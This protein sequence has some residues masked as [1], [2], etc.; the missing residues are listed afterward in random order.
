[1]EKGWAKLHG[2]YAR[3]E[4]TLACFAC[5]HLTGVPAETILHS[6]VKDKEKF[7]D[8]IKFSDGKNYTLLASSQGEGE[9]V[10]DKG[11]VE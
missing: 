1:M 6:E 7:W 10:N 5:S 2:T 3:A 4:G 9:K 11:I 8:Q